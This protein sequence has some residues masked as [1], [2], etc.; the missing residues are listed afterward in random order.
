VNPYE[1]PAAGLDDPTGPPGALAPVEIEIVP[2]LTRSWELLRQRPGTVIGAVMIPFSITIGVSALTGAVEGVT[3]QLG[4]STVATVVWVVLQVVGW[5]VPAWLQLGMVRVLLHVARGSSANLASL[6]G[7]GQLLFSVVIASIVV[8]I[9][10]VI[11]LVLLVVPGVVLALGWGFY[12]YTMVDQNL[13]PIES[14][15]ESWRVT[16]GY[17]TRLLIVSVAIGILALLA[18]LVTCG[19][20]VLVVLPIVSLGQTLVYDS[21]LRRKGPRPRAAEDVEPL[22]D[23]LDDV[24]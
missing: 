24:R 13:D 8:T 12:T 14:L 6:F 15:R 10:V 7:E 9:G 18:T 4:S 5:I 23:D 16:N 1:P 21:L 3:E 19:V 17:K 20:G 22:L 2:I 11:G